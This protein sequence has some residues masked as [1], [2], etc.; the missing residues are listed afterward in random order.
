VTKQSWFKKRDCFAPAGLAMTGF[1]LAIG[2]AG[3]ALANGVPDQVELMKIAPA[4]REEDSAKVTPATVGRLPPPEIPVVEHLEYQISWWGVPVA[5]LTMN[6]GPVTD[7]EDIDKLTKDNF[8]PGNL[9]KLDCQARTLDYLKGFI[10]IQ[11]HLVSFLDPK[12]RSPRRFEAFTKRR[13][14]RHESVELF[15]LEKGQAF[16]QL[17]KGRSATVPISPTTQDG[18]SLLYYVRTLPLQVGQ[19]IPLEVSAAGR[20]WQLN[21]KISRAGTVQIKK[22]KEWPAVAGE[23]KLAYPV[24][25][26]Q[27]AHALVWF[28]ADRERIPLLGR[29]NSN[30]GPVTVVLTCRTTEAGSTRLSS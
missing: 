20:N 8:Q 12:S 24:P 10:P 21:G 25:F 13:K 16:H 23:A 14:R 28:S 15:W 18:L 2:I 6:A 5:Q 22:M 11:V 9:L 26:F 30:I 7:K 17:P 19:E 27:G 1:L 29:I 4:S 3:Y